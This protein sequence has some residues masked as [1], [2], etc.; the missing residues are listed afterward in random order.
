MLN[1]SFLN[2]LLF[3]MLK[4]KYFRL[5]KPKFYTVKFGQ[6]INIGFQATIQHEVVVKKKKILLIFLNL[7]VLC[8]H[9]R[10]LL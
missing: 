4:S 8:D 1:D 3:F 2:A 7:E 5:I 9:C 6:T 10:C